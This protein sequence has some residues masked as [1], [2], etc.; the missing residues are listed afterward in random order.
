M[1]TRESRSFASR[2]GFSIRY[3]KRSE[4]LLAINDRSASYGVEGGV[5]TSCSVCLLYS[6]GVT[7]LEP[8][9]PV[10]RKRRRAG[11]GAASSPSSSPMLSS[12]WPVEHL[13]EDQR[14]SGSGALRSTCRTKSQPAPILHQMQK[15]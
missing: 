15:T 12:G 11:S 1:V 7:Q 2:E 4:D 13:S 5:A 10:V 8:S 14:I 3:T 6:E 9:F